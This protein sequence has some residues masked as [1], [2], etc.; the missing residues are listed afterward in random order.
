MSCLMAMQTL[1]VSR[2]YW[3]VSG[4]LFFQERIQY[5]NPNLRADI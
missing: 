5:S 4:L 2:T 3:M 1:N